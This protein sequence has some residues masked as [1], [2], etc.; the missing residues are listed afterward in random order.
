MT[1]FRRKRRGAS[2]QIYTYDF[3]LFGQRHKGSTKQVTPAAAQLFEDRLK[4]DLRRRRQGLPP[5]HGLLTTP[6]FTDWAEDFYDIMER[7]VR[8]A[9]R[10]DFLIRSVLRFWGARPEPGGKIPIDAT[11][12]YH[13]LRLGD[14]IRDP[15]W[16]ERF[17][18]WM[19]ERVK[20]AQTRNHYRSCVSMMFKI[21][22][23]PKYRQETNVF[24]NP[25][26]GF[27][28]ERTR[29]RRVS[30]NADQV[31]R[32][33]EAAS[34]H[35]RLAIAIGELAP[36]LRL[37]S[38]LSL[39]WDRH[40]NLEART[41]T[42][43]EHKTVD[44]TGEPMVVPISD[45]LLRILTAERKAHPHRAFVVM[46]QG[47]RLKSIQSGVREALLRANLP[48]GRQRENGITFH[49]LRHTAVTELLRQDTSL[50]KTKDAIGHENIHTT[51]GYG[52]MNV[53]DE[54]EQAEVLSKS[55]ALEDLVHAGKPPRRGAGTGGK[56][57]GTTAPNAKKSPGRRVALRASVEG[58]KVKKP[59]R[60][61]A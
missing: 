8:R 18:E 56:R 15:F 51:M 33:V 1:V 59:Q 19:R 21:A 49:T 9:D 24:M 10:V 53:E 31:R 22:S 20:S 46:Y 28:R 40:V 41:I 36:K 13:D 37:G 47:R 7:R 11:A 5:E 29:P 45:Q 57:G 34:P 43:W 38:I 4:E 2:D 30:L 54:R 52:H 27:D 42:V 44:A 6:R 55:F 26:T 14:V 17:E 16:L 60:N 58:P 35:V 48:W 39:E 23:K 61:R 32:W 12:P 50:A 3:E 25:A